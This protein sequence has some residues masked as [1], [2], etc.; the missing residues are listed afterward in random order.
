MLN[1]ILANNN[2]I[3]CKRTLASIEKQKLSRQGNVQ[4][5][6]LPFASDK[7]KE[8]EKIAM[9][10]EACSKLKDGYVTVACSGTDYTGLDLEGLLADMTK[11]QITKGIVDIAFAKADDGTGDTEIVTEKEAPELHDLKK[12]MQKPGYKL[13]HTI[14]PAYFFST[15]IFKT[16]DMTGD[17]FSWYLLTCFNQLLIE[18]ADCVPLTDAGTLS[19]GTASGQGEWKENLTEETA[20]DFMG[21]FLMPLAKFS[22]QTEE[23]NPLNAQYNL[24]F[25]LDSLNR[26]LNEA[27]VHYE[28][29]QELCRQADE[30]TQYITAKKV[31]LRHSALSKDIKRY[32]L[33]VCQFEGK[34]GRTIRALEKEKTNRSELINRILIFD[35]DKEQVEIAGANLY[36]AGDEFDLQVCR[37]DE[38]Y[39]AELFDEKV[40]ERWYGKPA[41][42]QIRFEVT[43]PLMP[44]HPCQLRIY[45]IVNGKR[46]KKRN[47]SFGRYTPF[48]KYVDLTMHKDGWLGH[49]DCEKGII[50]LE[51]YT[52]MRKRKRNRQL[53]WQLKNGGAHEKEIFRLRALCKRKA[54]FKRKE[55]WL[56]M[57]RADR[58]DDNGEAFFRYLC[59]TKPKGIDPYFVISENTKAAKE[60]SRIGKIVEPY[61][62]QHL[63]LHSIADYTISSQANGLVFNPYGDDEIY[64]RDLKYE[65]HFI[66]LQHGVINNDLSRSFNRY[67]RN[68]YGFIV[69]TQNEQQALLTD[70]YF[71]EKDRV[72][73]T[74]LARFDR[75]Y[76]DPKRYIT[77]MPTWRKSLSTLTERR[78]GWVLNKDFTKSEYFHF[79]ND[80]LNDSRLLAAAKTHGYTI[81]F[82]PHPNIIKEITSF[83]QDPQVKFF[84]MNVKYRDVFA[85]TALLLTDYSSVGFDF[86]YLRKPLIYCQFDYDTFFKSHSYERGYFDYENDGFGEVTRTFDETVD[87]IID[88]M[89]HNCAIK[90]VY[91]D[92]INQ[93]FAFDDQNNCQRIFD[94][95]KACK[96]SK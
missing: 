24:L 12:Y 72:W 35:V 71:L 61:S 28:W 1:I 13:V 31:V 81:C 10:Q 41:V 3:E 67:N 27:G 79:Y 40:I 36:I 86:A 48:S 21:K 4:I 68:T 15:Q 64:F 76:N 90:Q 87:M 70:N 45:T 49:A 43:V 65:N 11:Q 95:I 9:F 82:M 42:M 66:F 59:K 51:P 50:Y 52:R 26:V 14:F 83:H 80:L 23:I 5:L 18:G 17:V 56:I 62:E 88:Y 58:G 91:L 7:I 53:D 57:D 25:Y 30:I 38:V 63:L 60:F 73:L 6:T 92:R 89:E 29:P 85:Q 84:D 74:G 37:N 33:T 54:L 39:P 69:S 20:Q 55:I 32:L 34:E 96:A 22:K 19:L 78:D 8:S 44:G 93:T 46:S 47:L 94:R 16:N 77:I 2:D 75:S